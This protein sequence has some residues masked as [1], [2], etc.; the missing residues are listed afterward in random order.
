MSTPMRILVAGMGNLLRRDDG[1]GVHL[2]RTLA[3]APPGGAELLDAGTALI[4]V[5]DAIEQAD[6]TLVVD[7]MQAGGLPGALHLASAQAVCAPGEGTSLHDLGLY[8]A[9]HLLGAA[10]LMPDCIWVL[11][12]EPLDMDYGLE[13]SPPVQAAL[14]AAAAAVRRIVAHWRRLGAV[15]P[16]LHAQARGIP[17]EVEGPA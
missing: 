10:R 3:H 7:A 13:L 5:L 15:T 17:Q 1:V 6:A 16:H 11:G 2:I 4:S 14:P 12:V 8:S 9:L